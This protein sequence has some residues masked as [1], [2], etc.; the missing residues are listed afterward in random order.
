LAD[1]LSIDAIISPVIAGNLPRQFWKDG[2]YA[3]KMVRAASRGTPSA[4]Q[5]FG[6]A[7]ESCP[8]RPEPYERGIVM[9]NGIEDPS[10]C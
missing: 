1:R 3:G 10:V 2:E 6:R 9:C 5:I 4:L 7:R 8:E